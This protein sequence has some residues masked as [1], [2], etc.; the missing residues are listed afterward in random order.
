MHPT[1]GHLCKVAANEARLLKPKSKPEGPSPL[2][3]AHERKWKMG[4]RRSTSVPAWVPVLRASCL[5]PLPLRC[6]AE[7]AK[8][9]EELKE[10]PQKTVHSESP[11]EN[12]SRATQTQ[13]SEISRRVSFEAKNEALDSS[14]ISIMSLHPQTLPPHES[15][16]RYYS[17]GTAF[18]DCP[19][20]T[21]RLD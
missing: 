12:P 7:H 18:S 11:C 2:R 21:S 16:P 3:D 13:E 17:V 5:H 15:L 19:I 1:V 9:T 14:R 20:S 4:H 6:R 10:R 8:T